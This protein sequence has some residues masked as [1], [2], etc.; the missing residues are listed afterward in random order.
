MERGRDGLGREGV[1]MRGMVLCGKVEAV[2]MGKFVT[3]A[4]T[5]QPV[6]PRDSIVPKTILR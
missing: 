2:W 5:D 6:R 1:G 4:L 3:V